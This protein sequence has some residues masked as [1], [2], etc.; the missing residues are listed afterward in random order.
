MKGQLISLLKLHILIK[1]ELEGS[2]L[3]K[4]AKKSVQFVLEVTWEVW[5]Q[6]ACGAQLQIA[7]RQ[8]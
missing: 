2:R 6:R 7:I 3:N 5:R 8:K 4:P 1:I